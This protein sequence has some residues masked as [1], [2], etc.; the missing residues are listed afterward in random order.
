MSTSGSKRKMLTRSGVRVWPELKVET[1]KLTQKSAI[2][3]GLKNCDNCRKAL[4]LLKESGYNAV[5]RDVR[6]APLDARERARFLAKFGD[7]L[8]NRKSKTWRDLTESE[9]LQ[10]ADKL[11][12]QHPAVMK[13]P[14]IEAGS[15]R[16]TLGWTQDIQQLWAGNLP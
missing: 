11:L 1:A 7:E 15:E 12:S 10:P 3:Y 9:R 5:L 2:I 6:A 14:V 16:L 4:K 13:R 8:T